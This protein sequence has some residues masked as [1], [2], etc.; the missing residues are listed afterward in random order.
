LSFTVMPD[1]LGWMTGC[2]TLQRWNK[3]CFEL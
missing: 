3:S 1:G 2:L